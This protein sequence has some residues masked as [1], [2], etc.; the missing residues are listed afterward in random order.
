[1]TEHEPPAEP[2]EGTDEDAIEA[3]NSEDRVTKYE[4]IFHFSPPP[5]NRE[6]LGLVSGIDLPGYPAAV[7]ETPTCEVWRSPILKHLVGDEYAEATTT[8]ES[9]SVTIEAVSHPSC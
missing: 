4:R 1:M 8:D 5:S 7:R 6:R 3:T 2:A 9:T